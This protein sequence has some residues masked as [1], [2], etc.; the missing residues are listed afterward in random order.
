[1]LIA[2]TAWSVVFSDSQLYLKVFKDLPIPPKE[3]IVGE[4]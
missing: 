3:I 1:M 2:L 4:K